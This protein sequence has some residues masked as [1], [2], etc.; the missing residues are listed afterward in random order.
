MPKLDQ[1]LLRDFC[2]YCFVCVL[3]TGLK[4]EVQL[5]IGDV[6]EPMSISL[7]IF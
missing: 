1:F 7:F 4:F 3:L 2:L 6:S 5:E